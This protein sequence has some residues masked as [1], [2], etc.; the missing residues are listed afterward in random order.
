MEL[1]KITYIINELL[2]FCQSMINKFKQIYGNLIDSKLQKQ[3][4][5]EENVSMVPDF[6]Q[7]LG[8][9][10]EEEVEQHSEQ[11][12]QFTKPSIN[13]PFESPGL[14]TYYELLEQLL[15]ADETLYAM[16]LHDDITP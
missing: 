15:I 7:D 13:M 12:E 11:E 14:H 2:V 4:E 1:S 3:M 16:C 10:I 5:K 9:I 8:M 6:L